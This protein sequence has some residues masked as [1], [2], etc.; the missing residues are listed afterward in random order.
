MDKIRRLSLVKK[1]LD[2]W[3]KEMEKPKPMVS[4]ELGEK[5]IAELEQE[6]VRSR[7]ELISNPQT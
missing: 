5:I 3:R 1:R 6:V 7:K 2:E 4:K